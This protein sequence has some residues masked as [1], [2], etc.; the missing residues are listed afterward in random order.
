MLSGAIRAV[1]AQD[2]LAA[3]EF[4]IMAPVLGALL[5]GTIEICNALGANTRINSVA[6]TAADLTSQVS[7]LAPAD[8]TNIFGAGNAIMYP[9]VAT[10]TTIVVTSIVNKNGANT[11]CWSQAQNGTARSVGATMTVPT[12]LIVTGGSV[13]YAEASYNYTSPIQKYFVGAVKMSNT[14]YARP[15]MSLQVAY[16]GTSC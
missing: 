6:A 5:M 11:V 8:L 2:G 3:V 1:R 13:I 12:G 7:T 14:F 4:A 10:G 15:R 16:N 9:F